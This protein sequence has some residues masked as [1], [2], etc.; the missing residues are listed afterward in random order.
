MTEGRSILFVEDD[1]ILRGVISAAL[2]NKGHTVFERETAEEALGSM[3]RVV[4]PALIILDVDLP[5]TSG[6]DLCKRWVAMQQK[7]APILFLTA[8]DDVA[9]LQAC[10]A[11]GGDDFTIKSSPISQILE[12]VGYWLERRGRTLSDKRRQAILD[13]VTEFATIKAEEEARDTSFREI[14]GAMGAGLR[15]AFA[16]LPENFG[17]TVGEKLYLL[18]YVTGAASR[19][20]DSRLDL[21]IRFLDFLRACLLETQTLSRS[22]ASRMIANIGQFYSVRAFRQAMSAGARFWSDTMLGGGPPESLADI[23]T[24]LSGQTD[25]KEDA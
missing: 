13:Q 22:D 9:T 7:T 25:T 20:A 21:K 11:A 12:R 10:M 2:R 16:S 5:G 4:S 14:V 19:A 1:P 6:I 3:E 18:G 17:A 8:S 24:R 15:L 23:R